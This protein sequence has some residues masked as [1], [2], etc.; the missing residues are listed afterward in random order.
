MVSAKTFVASLSILCLIPTMAG[1]LPP[2]VED[3][4]DRVVLR[5][6]DC[7]QPPA[8]LVGA[9]D[10]R[11]FYRDA[12]MT[13]DHLTATVWEVDAKTGE[14]TAEVSMRMTWKPMG[15]GRVGEIATPAGEI[16][17]ILVFPEQPVYGGEPW[18]FTQWGDTLVFSLEGMT[19]PPKNGNTM[20]EYVVVF[21]LAG[22]PPAVREVGLLPAGWHNY[23]PIPGGDGDG[24]VSYSDGSVTDSLLMRIRDEDR[25]VVWEAGGLQFFRPVMSEDGSAAFTLAPDGVSLVE[26]DLETGETRRFAWKAPL[27]FEEDPL[28]LAVFPRSVVSPDGGRTLYYMIDQ[29]GIG[30]DAALVRADRKAGTLEPVM[31]VASDLGWLQAVDEDTLLVTSYRGGMR[32]ALVDLG[33]SEVHPVEDLLVGCS[34]IQHGVI[35]AEPVWNFADRLGSVKAEGGKAKASVRERLWDFDIE[36]WRNRA[37]ASER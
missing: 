27:S 20:R 28:A 11:A 4:G 8:Y 26:V 22:R 35:S 17:P 9:R 31:G 34:A 32:M 23:A 6:K 7:V 36:T 16:L 18:T 33:S 30:N 13:D 29:P 2:C 5:G 19:Y 10:G 21:D 12:A 15:D 14:Q 1:A 24:L 3:S 37:V 25:S